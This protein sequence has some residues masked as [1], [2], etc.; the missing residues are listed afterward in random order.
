MDAEEFS[1]S[2]SQ[3]DFQQN[4]QS[5]TAPPEV[6]NQVHKSNLIT[7]I[8]VGFLI[9]IVGVTATYFL[10]SKSSTMTSPAVV[11]TPTVLP[12]A[13]TTVSPSA[14]VQT[15]IPSETPSDEKKMVDCGK[16]EDPTCFLNRMNGCLP[17]TVKMTGSDNKTE[18]EM[19]IFGIEN[20]KCHFQ[21]KVNNTIDLNCFFPK[22]TMNWDTIDQ[23]FGNNKGLKKVVDDNCK[24]GW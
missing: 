11:S 12:S 5:N 23:T 15:P 16:A 2:N 18:I 22:G 6:S 1:K 21:R 8:S 3:T 17:V 20:E 14:L 24:S 10:Y 7:S 19:T 13:A 9:V 4:I